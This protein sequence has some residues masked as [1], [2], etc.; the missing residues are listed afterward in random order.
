LGRVVGRTGGEL[1]VSLTR[2][3]SVGDGIG[4][5]H[6]DGA[7]RGN[8]GFSV[9]RVRTLN[10][11][12]GLVTQAIATA[13]DV[14]A[15][16]V[17][18]RSS[19]P[20]LLEAARESFATVVSPREG[21]IQLHVRASGS[22]GGPLTLVWSGSAGAVTVKSA[23]ALS[24]AT[25]HPLDA[26]RLGAHVHGLAGDLACAELGEVG[27]IASDLLRFLPAAFRDLK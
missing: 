15:G 4:L 23:V 6:P 10:K 25:Q 1:L 2:P 24:P 27:M 11:A 9:T 13:A 22:A 20:T 17:V 26:A 7:A 12:E 16:W 21:A 14:P 18:V 3:L 8:T 19:Q 5:E